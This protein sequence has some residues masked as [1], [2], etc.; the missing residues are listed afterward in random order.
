MRK[1]NGAQRR[2]FRQNDVAPYEGGQFHCGCGCISRVLL[3]QRGYILVL[4]VSVTALV[5]EIFNL[6]LPAICMSC[7]VTGSFN[8]ALQ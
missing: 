7:T 2:S 6:Q 8:L 3:K 5:A 4:S 1:R